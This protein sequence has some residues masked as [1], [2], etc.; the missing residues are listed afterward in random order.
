M[1][2]GAEVEPFFYDMADKLR[3]AHL[4]IARSGA[5]TVA[6]VTMAGKPAIFVPYPWHKDQQ[7]KMN[8]DVVAD[9]GGAWVMAQDGFTQEALLA[10]LVPFLQDP[11]ILQKASVKSREC[12]VPDA[13]QKLADVV[14]AL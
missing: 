12:S 3:D 13:A 4:V 7:Q 6:E 5:S 8:A 10:R 14:Q 11:T 9:I 1:R 2:I